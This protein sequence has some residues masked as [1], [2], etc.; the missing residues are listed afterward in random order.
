MLDN[1]EKSKVVEKQDESAYKKYVREKI[2]NGLREME[3][4]EGIPQE[5]AEKIMECM[6]RDG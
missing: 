4:T 1:S 5:E 6:I 3:E 2:E